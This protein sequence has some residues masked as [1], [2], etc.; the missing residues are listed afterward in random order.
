MA[1][2]KI[3]TQPANLTVVPTLVESP[4]IILEIGGHTF[5]NAVKTK[6]RSSTGISY[7]VEYPNYMDSLSVVKVDGKINTY[8]VRIV[9]P[10]TKNNDPNFFDKLLGSVSK[11]RKAKISYGDWMSP[12]Y[13]YK[14]EEFIIS[15]VKTNVDTTSSKITYTI[16][17]VGTGFEATINKTNHGAKTD[18]PSNVIKSLLRDKSSGLLD[19]FT[20]MRNMSQVEQNQWIA[21]TDGVVVIPD[22][23]QML[24]PFEY[25]S[26]LVQSMVNPA[27]ATAMY[28]V[29]VCD[30]VN[31]LYGGPYFKIVE[32]SGNVGQVNTLDT[33]EVNIGY[34]DDNLVVSFNL[35]DNSEY[36]LLY[37][38]SNEI[39]NANTY[40]YYIDTHGELQRQFAPVY[41]RSDVLLKP[42]AQDE[43]WFRKMSSHPITAT[44]VL[45]GL[46]RPAVLMS[47]LRVNV[48][49][50]GQKH[51]SSGLYVITKQTDSINTQGY[52]TTL[53]LLRL[54]GDESVVI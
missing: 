44:L 43:A 5:G 42:T 38:Y 17:G 22:P 20:G 26:Y 48:Y 4:F 37:E 19:V 10:I 30:D 3:G 13:T 2:N 53:E 23:Q 36:S 51:T 35:N 1:N 9:Y 52:K 8:T 32:Y 7:Q 28:G 39:E 47:Y 14:D 24:S 6:R 40:Y 29:V 45:K 15:S 25:V 31:N 27:N 50:Y 34:P 12:T 46:I 33:Y 11:T 49:F 18:K 16:T 54:S 21:N 41:A